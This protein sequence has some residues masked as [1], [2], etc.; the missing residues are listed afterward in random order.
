MLHDKQ[1]PLVHRM[2]LGIFTALWQL[3]FLPLLVALV[4]LFV[5]ASPYHWMRI[6]AD[7]AWATFT[8]AYLQGIDVQAKCPHPFLKKGRVESFLKR[9]VS[10]LLVLC[11][12]WFALLEALG[13]LYSLQPK[14][15]FFVI[16]KPSLAAEKNGYKSSLPAPGQA[17]PFMPGLATPSPQQFSPTVSG[18]SYAERNSSMMQYRM[19]AQKAPIQALPRGQD[20]STSEN[21]NIGVPMFLEQGWGG[22]GGRGQ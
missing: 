20:P 2:C 18:E 21:K 17:V 16:S 1:V 13:V 15:G 12:F 14:Q 9:I 5:H 19:Q 3:A 8:L 10:W 6:P 7:F 11:S 22:G 4:A